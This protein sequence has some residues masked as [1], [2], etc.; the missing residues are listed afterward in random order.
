MILSLL[1]SLPIFSSL[2]LP[3]ALTL[4]VFDPN[5]LDIQPSAQVEAFQKS[6]RP[7]QT[8][9]SENTVE[10]IAG[11]LKRCHDYY[12]VRGIDVLLIVY[13]LMIACY[14]GSVH[15]V[16]SIAQ[17]ATVRSEVELRS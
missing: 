3:C 16:P 2:S 7:L 10:L 13:K 14:W 4:S 5:Q 1:C 11:V 15:V 9:F 12:K 17:A 8:S 6:A